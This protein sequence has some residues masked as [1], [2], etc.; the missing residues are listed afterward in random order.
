MSKRLSVCILATESDATN[1]LYNY[2][3]KEYEIRAVVLEKPVSKII[4]L[5]NRVRKL[6][7]L[8]VFGQLLFQLLVPEYLRWRDK[9]RIREIQ[10]KTNMD[11]GPIPRN[12]LIRVDSA[13]AST[14]RNYLKKMQCQAIVVCG[15]R[16]LNSA[17]INGVGC[18]LINWHAGI[19]PAYRGVHG[20]YWALVND[21]PTNC[22]VTVHLVDVGIDTGGI[23]YQE[24]IIPTA[25]DSFVTYPW[26][27]LAAALP[28]IPKAISSVVHGPLKLL[29]PKT[30]RSNQ[31][32][33]PT[34]WG[35]LFN[36]AIKRVY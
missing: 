22:G 6:G 31:W 16:I 17:L 27:Q 15:T 13:N 2:L 10:A 19:T 28:L 7:V 14:T 3:A 9:A 18:P 4:Y 5:K 25:N 21:D 29:E 20:G 23:L 24:R 11:T 35:Y 12:V 1:A 34:F 36:A 8:T 30:Q 33:H 32:Y 26:L